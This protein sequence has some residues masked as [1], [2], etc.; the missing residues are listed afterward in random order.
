MGWLAAHLPPEGASEELCPGP[1][2]GVWAP[3][4]IRGS[5]LREKP[6]LTP[7][8]ARGPVGRWEGLPGSRPKGS[9]L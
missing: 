4:A 2:G 7:T 9:L 5:W 8:P 6:P 1:S 3:W